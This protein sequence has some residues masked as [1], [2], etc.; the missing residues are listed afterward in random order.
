MKSKLFG[1]CLIIVSIVTLCSCNADPDADLPDI[2]RD[3][4]AV[5][6]V[7]IVSSESI[8]TEYFDKGSYPGVTTTEGDDSICLNYND[9]SVSMDLSSII[10]SLGTVDVTIRGQIVMKYE[11]YPEYYPATMKFNIYFS[12]AGE[13]HTLELT[14]RA[15]G[16][17]SITA[18]FVKVDG[19]RYNPSSLN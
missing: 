6:T 4:E 10:P 15:T 5:A 18:S 1:I 2:T 9:A 3:A 19:V 14:V 16:V 13:N 7:G 12:Y 11:A 8:M 17:S